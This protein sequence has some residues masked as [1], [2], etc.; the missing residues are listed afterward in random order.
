MKPI[1][2]GVGSDEDSESDEE[3]EHRQKERERRGMYFSTNEK[4][5]EQR[6]YR[7]RN[8]LENRVKAKGQS[9]KIH[10][11]LEDTLMH[12]AQEKITPLAE[13][14]LTQYNMCRELE[15]IGGRANAAIR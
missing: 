8:H 12:A 14:V 9:G 10:S 7:L 4:L 13:C 11:Q 2:P 1:L 5:V 15:K 6:G 3:P